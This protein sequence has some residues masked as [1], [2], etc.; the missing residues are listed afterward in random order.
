MFISHLIRSNQ[1]FP[2]PAP[3]PSW[4]INTWLCHSQAHAPVSKEQGIC[5]RCRENYRHK[6]VPILCPLCGNVKEYS[7]FS[8][9]YCHLSKVSALRNRC[10]WQQAWG[11]VGQLWFC[12]WPSLGPQ[13]SPQTPGSNFP[14]GRPI[15][16]RGALW[17]HKN[18]HYKLQLLPWG[19]YRGTF[20][21]SA[22]P[23]APQPPPVITTCPYRDSLHTHHWLSQCPYSILRPATYWAHPVCI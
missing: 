16:G 22:C 8:P 21:M 13:I 14:M 9:L 3:T 11:D 20:H 2:E 4:G 15:S 10:Q 17:R 6:N 1:T 18:F 12:L 5:I 19:W 23:V 7:L